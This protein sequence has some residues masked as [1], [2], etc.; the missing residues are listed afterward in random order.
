MRSVSDI[1]NIESEAGIIATILAN[2]EFTFYSENLRPNHFSDE[3]NAYIYYAVSELAKRGIEKVD[4][5]NITNILNAK[6][7]TKKMTET[8]TIQA[9][10]D[11]IDLSGYIARSTV[12][13][14]MLLVDNV[15]DKAFRRETYNKLEECKQ[16]CF[17]ENEK[18][19]EQ[20]IYS[21][22]DNVLMEYS[23]TNDVPPFKDKV[24]EYWADI[25]KHQESGNNGIPFKFPLLNEYVV[26]EPDEL[27]VFCASQ[28]QG[29]SMM[30]LNCAVDILKQGKSVLYIDSEL[31]SK[32]FTARLLAHLSGI[33]F[34]RLRS[35]NYTPEEAERINRSIEWIKEKNFTHLYMPM[36]DEKT[37]YAATK[38]IKHASG[39]D[40]LIIDYFKSK[41][42]G[43]AWSS[44]TELGR[45]VDMVKNRICGDMHIAGLGAA[46]C[47][48]SGKIAD[49]AKIARNASTIAIITEKTPEEIEQ[50][51]HECG[52]K[53][54]RVWFNRNGPQ[55]AED[56]YISLKFDGNH[57]LYEQAEKQ[58]NTF[59]PF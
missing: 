52:N 9:L 16:L 22:L 55:M 8:L 6:E 54:L 24:D 28:K 47:T 21:D 58:P 37:I 36:F 30:L 53:K 44:Y 57:I 56:E 46:Q 40:V 39:L 5:Y 23:S 4:A 27:C 45:L 51:G 18:D 41:A 34:K 59:A 17:A 42:E 13:E 50:D 14:Y 49:S 25:K 10:K 29:K 38:K 3:Q 31:S 11:V 33:E 19:I 7:A 26:I 1:K 35:G 2:P 43:D 48:A 12:E 32:M 20:K 15:L